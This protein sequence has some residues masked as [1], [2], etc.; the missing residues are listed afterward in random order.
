MPLPGITLGDCGKKIGMEAIDNGFMIFN[1]IRIPREN[2]LNR[3][4]NVSE[5]GKF[6]TF[7]E[8]AD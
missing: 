3:L 6:E 8:S 7:I 4:S 2:L 1:D 5:E